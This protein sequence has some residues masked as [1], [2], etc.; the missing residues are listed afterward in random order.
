MQAGLQKPATPL[1][2][3]QSLRAELARRFGAPPS[4]V[5]AVIGAE[6]LSPAGGRK[7]QIVD[8]ATEAVVSAVE[9]DGPAVVDRAVAAAR[10]AFDTGPWPRLPVEARQAMLRRLSDLVEAHAE[11]LAY[12]ECLN[13]GIPMRHLALGQ[14]PRAAL[15][16]RFFAE[17]IGQTAG[18]IYQQNADYLTLVTRA[19]VGAA[20]LI[21]PW[22]APL[23]L[24]SMK[25]AGCIAFG[26]TCVVKPAEQTPLAVSRFMDL[27][28]E[29]GLPP[30]V[31]NLVNGPGQVTGEALVRHPGVNLISF[32]GGT[33]TGRRIMAAAGQGLKATSIELGGK[34]ANIV[35]TRR[36]TRP[37]SASS[38]A[39]GSNAWP[40]PASC[41]RGRSPR[42]SW[43]PSPRARPRFGWATR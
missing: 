23:A 7:I 39:T 27:V 4:L 26:N 34:S 29:A 22:N 14:I 18:Q 28:F 17:Y 24:T 20:G 1:Q 11:E 41:C 6:R 9:E 10:A 43:R 40:G 15:N 13:S 2:T 12:L 8:P 33:E 31:V 3:M 35:F 37:C 38:P 19:P 21:G 32:T 30:G 5:T 25:I 42:A 36:W 16:F